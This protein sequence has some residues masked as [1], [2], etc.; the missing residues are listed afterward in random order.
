MKNKRFKPL[1][2]KLFWIIWVPTSMLLLG[3]TACSCFAPVA[4]FIM[5]PINV[6]VF[7]FLISSLFA[8]VELRD[9]SLFIK[10]GFFMKKEIPYKKIRGVQKVRKVYADSM[11][12]IKNAMDHINIKY[13]TYD[14]VS[15]SV[16]RN[17]KFISELEQRMSQ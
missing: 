6:F 1:F 13:N 4:L 7:Y 3:V 17:D 15:V 11:A 2:D 10:F 14:I 9:E 16:A 8:Y 12:A 5:I